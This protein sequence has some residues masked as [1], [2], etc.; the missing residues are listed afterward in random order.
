MGKQVSQRAMVSNAFQHTNIR[1]PSRMEVFFPKILSFVPLK[2]KRGRSVLKTLGN[3]GEWKCRH[4]KEILAVLCLDR[5]HI[6][7]TYP[8]NGSDPFL[9]IFPL[10][11]KGRHSPALSHHPSLEWARK[12]PHLWPR[13]Q[14]PGKT[15]R[16]VTGVAAFL[17]L[18]IWTWK[19]IKWI[20]QGSWLKAT[21]GK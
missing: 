13:W 7:P 21:G 14:R 19:G 10:Y 6:A 18:W 12:R 20:L 1:S 8:G 9:L 15:L 4:G 5:T 2:R 11:Q 17:H 3:A 16:N